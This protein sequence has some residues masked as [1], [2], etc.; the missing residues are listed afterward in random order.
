MTKLHAN[1]IVIGCSASLLL[2][3]I[4]AVTSSAKNPSSGVD[5]SG[6]VRARWA[7][8]GLNAKAALLLGMAATRHGNFL[9]VMGY[10]VW[11]EAGADYSTAMACY[12]ASYVKGEPGAASYMLT[13][14]MGALECREIAL[15]PC[16]GT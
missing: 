15:K 2:L 1:Q 10:G 13:F 16:T 14:M 12:R 8:S 11:D 7:D 4:A 6:N 3:A 9:F 5:P